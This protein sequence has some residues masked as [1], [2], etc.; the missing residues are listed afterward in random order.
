MVSSFLEKQALKEPVFLFNVT[1][2]DRFLNAALQEKFF[3]KT[4]T[5]IDSWFYGAR[6]FLCDKCFMLLYT[7][8]RHALIVIK[9]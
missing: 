4:E 2:L 3:E 1:Q 6:L 5:Y 7:F 9:Q 8:K